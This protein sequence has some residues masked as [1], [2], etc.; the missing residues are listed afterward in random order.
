MRRPLEYLRAVARRI[1]PGGTLGERTVKSGFW[2]F[3]MNVSGRGLRILVI[4]L[5]ARQIS[6]DAFGAYGLALI[7]IAAAGEFSTL[8]I[9][10]ALIQREEADVDAFLDTAWVLQVIRGVSLFALLYLLAPAMGSLFS[11]PASVDILRVMALGALVIGL[12][13]PAAVYFQKGLAFH[14]E[15]AYQVGGAVAEFITALVLVWLWGS[16]WALVFGYLAADFARTAISYLIHDY[17]PLPS[18]DPG[19]A[20]ELIG[21]GKWI[22]GSSILYFLYDRGDDAFI[23]WAI[24]TAALG[25]YQMSHRLSNAPATE[26]S[27]VV[28]DVV[29]PVFSRLQGEPYSLRETFLKSLRL[30]AVLTFPMGAGIIVVAPVFVPTVLGDQWTP[31]TTALQILAVH[32]V[33]RSLSKPMSA[34]WKAIGR[35]DYGT[36]VSAVKVAAIA[37]FIVP[38]TAALGI[39]GAALTITGVVLFPILPLK[40]LLTVR[41]LKTTHWE[42]LT[43]WMYP[44]VASGVMGGVVYYLRETLLIDPSIGLFAFLVG[45]GIVVYAFV[46]ALLATR[47]SWDLRGTVEWLLETAVG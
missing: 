38:A 34:L 27:D 9:R 40:L 14:R 6:P 39:N 30:T 22:T 28:A 45:A 35:P 2:A 8:G 11:A 36:K 25:W 37:V 42:V 29:F 24:G 32:G 18:F 1:V 43:E 15:F 3:G 23:G 31:M 12:R 4:L 26:V 33:V 10:E 41:E 44:F 17:R 7:A 47:S 21:Y 19:Y 16:V 5:V 20:R 46:V 13:N